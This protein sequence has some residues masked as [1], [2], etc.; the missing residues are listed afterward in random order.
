MRVSSRPAGRGAQARVCE[1]PGI[2]YN[3]LQREVHVH[4]PASAEDVEVP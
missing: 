2:S 1:V 3:N 4:P